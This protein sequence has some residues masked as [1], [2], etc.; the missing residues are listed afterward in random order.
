MKHYPS[1]P[2]AVWNERRKAFGTISSAIGVL[3]WT[4]VFFRPLLD[5]S[6]D[7]ADLPVGDAIAWLTIGTCCIL[8]QQHLLGLLKKAPEAPAPTNEEEN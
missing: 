5:N 1:D 3:I 2:V 7:A 6:P 4:A 8:Y